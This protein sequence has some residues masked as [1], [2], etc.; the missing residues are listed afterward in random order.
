MKTPLENLKAARA[1]LETIEPDKLDLKAY[2]NPACGTIMCAAG[3]LCSL[4]EF[5]AQG[6]HLTLRLDGQWALSAPDRKLDR[7]FGKDSFSYLFSPFL[8]GEV[9]ETL[10][11]ELRPGLNWG[12]GP[13]ARQRG[14]EPGLQKE[15]ALARIDHRIAEMEAAV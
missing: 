10:L 14:N 8:A 4:P 1:Y 2:R 12:Y 5:A 7:L 3:H 9:D 6:M 13:D 15:L 11:T